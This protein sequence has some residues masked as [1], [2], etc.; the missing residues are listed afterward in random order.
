MRPRH[1]QRHALGLGPLGDAEVESGVIHQ[2]NAVRLKFQNV[3]LNPPNQLPKEAQTGDDFG[4]PHD[5]GVPNVLH[6]AHAQR[7]H[8][9]AAHAPELE[10]EVVL[11]ECNATST[12]CLLPP[13]SAQAHKGTVGPK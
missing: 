12:I 3:G 1:V 10:V 7:V 11:E 4:E 2:Q 13:C 6:E 9:I 5:G 8:L